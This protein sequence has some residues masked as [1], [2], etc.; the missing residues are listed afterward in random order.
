MAM[1]DLP[2]AVRFENSEL[3][4]IPAKHY[5]HIF[6]HAVNRICSA[7]DPRPEAVAVELGPGICVAASIWLRELGMGS[8]SSKVLPVMLAL[9][10][11]NRMIHPSFKERSIKLQNN[12]GKDLSELHPETLL[13]ELGYS[14]HSVLFMSPGDS[15]IE[16]LRCALELNIPA[17]GVDLEETATGIRRPVVI[18]DPNSIPEGIA[19]FVAHNLTFTRASR[20]EEIDTRREIVMAARLKA[21]LLGH[22]R[23]LFT[24]GMAHW[25]RIQELLLDKT[26]QPSPIGDSPT[27]IAAEYRRVVVH[28]VI[29][30]QHMDPFP[31]L[32]HA[33]EKGRSRAGKLTR[34]AKTKLPI[35]A[36]QIYLSC[37]KSAYEKYFLTGTSASPMSERSHD[38]EALSLFEQ[39]I[40]NLCLLNHC[41]VPDLALIAQ[42]ASQMM[43]HGFEQTVINEFM[44]YPWVSPKDYPNC[45]VLQPPSDSGQGHGDAII[46]DGSSVIE[47]P[48]FIQSVPC[49]ERSKQAH[50]ISFE[51][52]EMQTSKLLPAAYTWRPWEYLITSMSYRAISS[53]I[54]RRTKIDPVVF[55]GSLLDGIDMKSTVR[56]WSRGSK[57]IYVRDVLYEKTPG[58]VNPMDGFPIVWI[59]NPG[60]HSNSYWKVLHE[61]SSF[62]EQHIRDKASF[63]RL[64]NTRGANLV[65][66][67]AYGFTAMKERNPSKSEE[68]HVDHYHGIAVFQPICWTNRQ[69]ARWAEGTRYKRNP[70]CHDAHISQL[71]PSE[72]VDAYASEYGFNI[73]D[74]DWETALMLMAL[75]YAHNLLTVVAPDKYRISNLV[76]EKARTMHVSVAIASLESF[77][78]EELSELACGPMV[79]VIAIEPEVKYSRSLE[80][81]IGEPQTTNR[82][83]VPLEWLNFGGRR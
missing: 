21:I 29:A 59:L 62:M 2:I 76:L 44:T 46:V 60:N 54:S 33:Y 13:H 77:K 34:R 74:H 37:L 72:L 26:V 56:A 81:V 27:R 57:L 19:A 78:S 83:L 24:C 30:A 5:C 18:Q 6:A 1:D 65:A 79:P 31:P 69:Y 49:R 58:V 7:S 73:N 53:G 39:Y 55:E 75:P 52:N 71:G 38:I 35:Q 67:L 64:K 36:E 10:K 43:S 28:P 80:K 41:T 40:N 4:V 82:D 8:S 20:D 61:P 12:V 25:L 66:L 70:Y 47:G 15:I 45:G 32:V 42:A 23:V 63:L 14:S 16:A 48:M 50:H 17:Y 22:K 11:R 9:T 68:Y 51:W 3:R